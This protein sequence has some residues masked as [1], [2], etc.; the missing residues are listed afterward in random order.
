MK[1]FAPL[2]HF[3]FHIGYFGPLVMGILDSSF[4][5]LPFGNDLV[6][7]GLVAQ[8]PKGIALYVIS[9][10]VGSCLGAI[11]LA[12]VSRKL[13]EEGIRRIAGDRRY[14]KLRKRVGERSAIA[15][16]LAGIAPPPF[17]FTTVIAAVGALDYP[18]WRIIAVNF[19]ARGLRFTILA[20]LALKFGKA[21]LEIAKSPAFEWTMIGFI[22]ICV[23][24]SAV[25][26]W[27]WVKKKPQ[28]EARKS[29]TA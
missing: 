18:I 5:V 1:F 19:L 9:A 23:I 22:A 11:L 3:L 28:G 26:I 6:V 4:L 15:V 2:L 27:N 13:G 24:A 14:E 17:P 12:L 7:V 8:H 10:A 20:I 25:S 21:V 29:A 16:F